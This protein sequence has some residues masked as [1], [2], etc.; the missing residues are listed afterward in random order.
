MGTADGLKA[1]V[2]ES[3]AE[4]RD[5]LEAARRDS[6]GEQLG[7]FSLPTRFEGAAGDEQRARA[8][9]ARGPGRPPGAQNRATTDMRRLLR[10]RGFDPLAWKV[11]WAQHSPESLAKEL[12]CTQ[13]EA[14]D[15][16]DRLYGE[17]MTYFYGRALPVDDQGRTPPFL[18]M[19]IGGVG[20]PVA[21]AAPWDSDP[22]R[23]EFMQETQG[24]D[25]TAP[26]VSH[27]DVSHGSPK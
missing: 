14:F 2:G 26:D 19:Q 11:R 15:R 6:E 17:L 7:L 13:A 23:V 10:A 22:R 9:R 8:E 4:T 20:A 24:V 12:H 5:A 27:A 16:L 1:A 25:E 3:V 18:V 21:G